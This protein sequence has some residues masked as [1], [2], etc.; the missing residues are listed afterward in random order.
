MYKNQTASCHLKDIGQ[1]IDIIR[2]EN[3]YLILVNP[4][5]QQ[6]YTHCNN[7]TQTYTINSSSLIYF[8]NCKI[9][10]NDI[11]YNNENDIFWDN[12]KLFEMPPSF[13]NNIV[14]L[15]KQEEITIPKL[16]EYRFQN[17]ELIQNLEKSSTKNFKLTYT[18]FSSLTVL[19]IILVIIIILKK[20][21]SI[22]YS[23]EQRINEVPATNCPKPLWPSLHFR[24]GGVTIAQSQP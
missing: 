15:S 13:N 24:E 3:D 21:T 1:K 8:T 18:A 22:I 16:N 23:L 14:I 2:P 20:S 9:A 12:G 5:T 7:L 6:I 11:W 4:P 17:T 10:I 19:T